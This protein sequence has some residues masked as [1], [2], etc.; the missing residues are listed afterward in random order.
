MRRRFV[1]DSRG[2][3]RKD[4]SVCSFFAPTMRR[5]R[6]YYSNC[7]LAD[8]IVPWLNICLEQR[9]ERLIRLNTMPMLFGTN[10]FDHNPA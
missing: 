3:S 7:G 8:D 6:K 10:L 2:N 5:S 4:L 1:Q 9:L